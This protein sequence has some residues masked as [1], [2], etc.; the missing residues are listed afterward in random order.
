MAPDFAPK[1]SKNGHFLK[2]NTTFKN[3]KLTK[4][5]EFD[6]FLCAKKNEKSIL[7]INT[8]IC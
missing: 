1:T 4:N 2:S 8:K 7:L 6:L 3:P 5:C